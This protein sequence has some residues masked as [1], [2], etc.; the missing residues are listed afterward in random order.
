MDI[1][2]GH[3]QAQ[4]PAP[5]ASR[6]LAPPSGDQIHRGLTWQD[7][8]GRTKSK[9]MQRL[10]FAQF[11]RGQWPPVPWNIPVDAEGEHLKM[12]LEERL[13]SFVT[14]KNRRGGEAA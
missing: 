12:L 1:S 14:K 9:L 13:A 6:M 11:R 10:I 8:P 5:A 4:V 3:S 7:M 2:P